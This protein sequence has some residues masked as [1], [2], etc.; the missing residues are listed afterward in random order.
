MHS[1][2]I[3]QMTTRYV[4]LNEN[5]LGYLQDGSMFMGVLAGSVIKGGH[6]WKNGP[7]AFNPEIDSVR[8]A[9]LA[10]FKAFRVCATGYRLEG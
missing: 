3:D 9:T 5:T 10:D 6:D 7:V 1:R 4:V 2:E 8:P